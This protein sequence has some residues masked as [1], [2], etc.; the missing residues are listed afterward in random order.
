MEFFNRVGNEVDIEPCSQNYLRRLNNSKA[1]YSH[2]NGEESECR[3][4]LESFSDSDEI[5]KTDCQHI[6]H[7]EC[8][9]AWLQRHNTCP[10]CR[11][12]LE[13][14]QEVLKGEKTYGEDGCGVQRS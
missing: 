3:I 14:Q 2:C 10:L 7:H 8:L 9:K 5:N 6:F 13:E 11:Q 12:Q 4:C 1:T